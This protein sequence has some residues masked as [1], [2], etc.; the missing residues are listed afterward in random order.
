LT[1]FLDDTGL[2]RLLE[3]FWK[4]I[5]QEHHITYERALEILNFTEEQS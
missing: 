1:K 4:R 3:I 2:M 5:R